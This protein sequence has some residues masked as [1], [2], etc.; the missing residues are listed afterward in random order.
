MLVTMA[1]KDSAQHRPIGTTLCS[2][3]ADAT[4]L[5]SAE[6]L[7]FHV[8][9]LGYAE[10]GPEWSTHGTAYT[11]GTHHLHFVCGGRAQW[12]W[13]GGTLDLL[14]GH[15]YWAPAQTP[16]HRHCDAS[17]HHFVLVF[18]CEWLR[19]IDLLWNHRT[20]ICLGDWNPRD[21]ASHWN[22]GPL[23]LPTLLSVDALLR[24][25]FARFQPLQQFII[26]QQQLHGRFAPMFE[27]L[28][29]RPLPDASL[30]V[31]DIAREL[32]MTHNGFSRL[33]RRHFG[34]SP[35]AYL[36]HRVN[37]AACELLATSDEPIRQ[38]AAQLG[39]SNEYYF[40]RFFQ[41]LN[42]ISP[43]RYRRLRSPVTPGAK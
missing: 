10:V 11:D 30:Q 25:L 8:I 4:L 9:Y 2:R 12:R 43:G 40:N 42:G 41:Q 18:R 36:H 15:A 5:D 22:H 23:T 21:Y 37:Q 16:L 3:P 20:P 26:Q 19:G 38:I 31:S 1:S 32:G 35:K 17:Y 24:T 13:T 14:P 28:G 34:S 39:F 6:M 33:F 7:R 27:L 29:R